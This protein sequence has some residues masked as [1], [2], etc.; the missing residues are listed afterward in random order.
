MPIAIIGGWEEILTPL[1]LSLH[2]YDAFDQEK[3]VSPEQVTKVIDRY[4]EMAG[5]SDKIAAITGEQLD[6]LVA[7]V[8]EFDLTKDFLKD[9]KKEAE[10]FRKDQEDKDK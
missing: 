2:L 10:S 1:E 7:S 6:K 8:S 9:F 3:S 4:K 5:F